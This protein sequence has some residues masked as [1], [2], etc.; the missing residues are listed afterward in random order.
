MVNE[1]DR[2]VDEED[3]EHEDEQSAR[4]LAS[5]YLLLLQ[6]A[7]AM[8]SGTSLHF[9]MTLMVGLPLTDNFVKSLFY[10]ILFTLSF[11]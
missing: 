4:A 1:A 8:S 5:I 10:L 2:E 6:S 9:T 3:E 11:F 7:S